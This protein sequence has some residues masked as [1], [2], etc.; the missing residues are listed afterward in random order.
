MACDCGT[1]WTFHLNFCT[2]HHYISHSATFFVSMPNLTVVWKFCVKLMSSKSGIYFCRNAYF[3]CVSVGV[4]QRD[5]HFDLQ[6][7]NC[8]INCASMK[9]ACIYFSLLSSLNKTSQWR[10]SSIIQWDTFNGRIF[11]HYW[12]WSPGGTSDHM[13][14][15]WFLECCWA[16]LW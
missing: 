15:W 13:P 8:C 7:Y 6:N 5:L 10:S 12:V 9:L 4:F 3:V 14:V 2:R 11:L 1:P 16:T